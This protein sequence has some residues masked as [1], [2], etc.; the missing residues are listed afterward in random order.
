[1]TDFSMTRPL[2]S[3]IGVRTEIIVKRFLTELL[4]QFEVVL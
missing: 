3:V 2:E 4:A 1:M